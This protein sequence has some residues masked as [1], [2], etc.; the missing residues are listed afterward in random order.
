MIEHVT[1]T[2]SDVLLHRS[3]TPMEQYGFYFGA[4]AL[5]SFALAYQHHRA[6]K[7]AATETLTLPAGDGKALARE[8]QL[9]Y[10]GV[11][12]LVVAADWLQV[13]SSVAESQRKEG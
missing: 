5:L 12:G 13:C 3:L 9:E 11:Y 2:S 4:L 6:D 8:F 10:F 7:R 1:Y